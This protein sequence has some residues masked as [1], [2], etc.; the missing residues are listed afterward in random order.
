MQSSK[1]KREEYYEFVEKYERKEAAN[2][3]SEWK[4]L[5]SSDNPRDYQSQT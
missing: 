1:E 3:N 2:C 4:I 5:D